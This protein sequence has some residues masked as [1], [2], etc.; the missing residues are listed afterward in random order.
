MKREVVKACMAGNRTLLELSADY[1]A[2]KSTI[3]EWSK[4]YGE[5]CQYKHTTQ[6]TLK[7]ILPVK[8]V[9]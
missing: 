9:D 6:K 1:N 4:K 8:Y 3:R 5:E 7:V 2:A